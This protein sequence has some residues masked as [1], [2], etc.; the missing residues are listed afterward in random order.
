MALF[1]EQFHS[2]V[3]SVGGG[4]VGEVGSRGRSSRSHFLVTTNTAEG[5]KPEKV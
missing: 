3:S 1:L 2:D 5:T 4:G